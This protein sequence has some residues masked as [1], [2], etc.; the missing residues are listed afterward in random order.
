[1]SVGAFSKSYLRCISLPLTCIRGGAEPSLVRLRRSW[2]IGL[3][4][5][6]SALR[7]RLRTIVT[8]R[9]LVVMSSYG[10]CMRCKRQSHGS[11]GQFRHPPRPG[12]GRRSVPSSGAGSE[13]TSH[14][15]SP[16]GSLAGGL[17]HSHSPTAASGAPASEASSHGSL[18]APYYSVLRNYWARNCCCPKIP[19]SSPGLHG[20]FGCQPCTAESPT[21]AAFLRLRTQ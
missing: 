6:L 5:C 16:P 8:L 1:M 18:Y 21:R 15:H 19:G 17:S 10:V 4:R 7:F 14:A 11:A 2:P 12:N 20:K 13:G 9:N 3:S